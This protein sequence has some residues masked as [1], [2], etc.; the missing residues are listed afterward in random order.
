MTSIGIIG[1]LGEHPLR[2]E[3]LNQVALAG[4][5]QTLHD[6]GRAGGRADVRAGKGGVHRF[7]THA[8]AR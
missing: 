3:E 5:P 7:R 6:V 2:G 1:M 8:V 4:R